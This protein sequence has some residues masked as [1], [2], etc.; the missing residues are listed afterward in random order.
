MFNLGAMVGGIVRGFTAPVSRGNERKAA[1]AEGATGVQ[2]RVVR[3]SVEERVV[4]T[5][6]GSVRLRR[7]V[8]DEVVPPGPDGSG[9]GVE[10]GG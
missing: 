2:G 10:R 3:T 1:G 7:T 8:V 5:P 4:E 6:G 9:G